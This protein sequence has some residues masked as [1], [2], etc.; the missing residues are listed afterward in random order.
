MN[1]TAI[2]QAFANSSHSP[3][4]R[5]LR[6]L[7]G[8]HEQIVDFCVPVNIGFPPPAFMDQ[9]HAQLAD[10][11][12]YYPSE[13]TA[14][15]E[16]FASVLNVQPTHLI[17]GNG[18]TELFYNLLSSLGGKR[19]LLTCVPTF[20]RWTDAPRGSGHFVAGY[21]R[22][23]ENNFAIDAQEICKQA[24]L[25]RIDTVVISNPNNPTGHLTEKMDLL[26]LIENLRTQVPTLELVVVDE[27]FLD[28]SPLREQAS[29][30]S[31]APLIDGLIV[32]KSLGKSLGLHGTRMGVLVASSRTIAKI[33]NFVPYWNVNGIAEAVIDLLPE[34]LDS[35]HRGLEQ[36]I[37]ATQAMRTQLASLH[38]VRAFPTNANYVYVELAEAR[39]P[40]ALRDHLLINHRLFVRSCGNK[41]GATA[42]HFRIATRPEGEVGRLVEAM[43]Y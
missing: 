39:D 9:L 27:S 8:D 12:K 32:L 6:G 19:R 5:K 25:H 15:N 14:I 24:C 43:R 38:G 16:K 1:L 10:R 11:L 42:R 4:L 20:G 7:L 21:L 35:F 28:F 36:T 22:R 3:G 33:E 18:S 31:D 34:H 29:L 13:P 30:L 2:N 41:E 37:K 23:M 26:D 17:A 40:I